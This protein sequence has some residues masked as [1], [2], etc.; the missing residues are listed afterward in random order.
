MVVSW[1]DFEDGF[2][3]SVSHSRMPN[4]IVVVATIHV[5]RSQSGLMAWSAK[6][7][8]ITGM[9]LM[10]R[11]MVSCAFSDLKLPLRMLKKPVVMV[12]ISLR[13]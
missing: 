1:M 6:P 11:L 3:A 5:S 8:M 2:L 12:A 7:M 10:T 9:E 4:I 13:K